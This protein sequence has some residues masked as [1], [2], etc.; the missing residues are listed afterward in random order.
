VLFAPLRRPRFP[1]VLCHGAPGHAAR[2]RSRSS[3]RRCFVGL[4]GFDVRGPV[5]F[6]KMQVHYWN[7]V[8]EILRDTVGAEVFVTSVPPCMSRLLST[9]PALM[10][11]RKDSV[12]RR[13]C[14]EARPRPLRA[15][16]RSRRE[17]DG[18]LDGRARLPVPDPPGSARGV[19]S[20][21]AHDHLDSA[22][23]EPIHGQVCRV[24]VRS[25]LHER[26]HASA[27]KHRARPRDRPRSRQRRPPRARSK[28]RRRR[29]PRPPRARPARRR[30]GPRSPRS[31]R[32]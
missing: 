21:L 11:C 2:V 16:V 31:R 4:Y 29:T 20:A 23:R 15:R 13:A 32:R 17:P 10:L 26:A 18:A 3:A 12:N 28:P 27:G 6:P 22:P 9:S 1:I 5:A 8:L 19:R 25:V 7:N 14:T 24:C 30:L